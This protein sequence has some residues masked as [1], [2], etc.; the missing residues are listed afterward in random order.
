MH[1]RSALHKQH[2]MGS[3][4]SGSYVVTAPHWGGEVLWPLYGFEPD[5]PVQ[6][7]TKKYL[8]HIEGLQLGMFLQ[9]ESRTR[10]A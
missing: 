6:I 8:P 9:E 10:A 1:S 4:V 7:K 3:E 2:A 5:G